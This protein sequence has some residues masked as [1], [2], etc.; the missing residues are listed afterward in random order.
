MDWMGVEWCT[1]KT[2]TVTNK[3]QDSDTVSRYTE[4]TTTRK[5]EMKM[6]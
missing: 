4:W 3:E 5:A 2:V 1:Q 6:P